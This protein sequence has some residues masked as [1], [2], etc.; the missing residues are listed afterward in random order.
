M[1]ILFENLVENYDRMPEFRPESLKAFGKVWNFLIKFEKFLL[2]MLCCTLTLQ[3]NLN[4]KIDQ[5][6]IR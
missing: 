2:D 3:Q 1:C 6:R 5:S 4:L